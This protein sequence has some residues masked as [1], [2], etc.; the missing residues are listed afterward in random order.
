MKS[1]LFSLG[2]VF[3][4]VSLF[5]WPA[6]TAQVTNRNND[7]A[8]LKKLLNILTKQKK[9]QPNEDEFK[10]SD[11]DPMDALK[12]ADS[13]LNNTSDKNVGTENNEDLFAYLFKIESKPEYMDGSD[14]NVLFSSAS[15][16]NGTQSQHFDS[17]RL[18][19]KVNT[20]VLAKLFEILNKNFLDGA[21]NLN[22]AHKT[23]EFYDNFYKTCKCL[24][25]KL[26]KK[27]VTSI[28]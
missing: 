16:L 14:K 13:N 1:I 5:S 6:K 26:I 24:F 23:H 4:Y 10:A 21:N 9:F 15:S 25:K 17:D 28:L 11:Q 20:K 27:F 22:L 8:H 12:Q 2:F 19:P 18:M 7:K 3:F